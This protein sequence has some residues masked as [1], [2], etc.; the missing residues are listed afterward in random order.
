MLCK[1]VVC[2][3]D[4]RPQRAR[5]TT[6]TQTSN[7]DA[8]F[9]SLGS[10]SKFGA[11]YMED[12]GKVDTLFGGSGNDNIWLDT[13]TTKVAKPEDGT[14]L[15]DDDIM[16]GRDIAINMIATYDYFTRAN[17]RS[18]ESTL[19]TPREGLRVL[20]RGMRKTS[21]KNIEQRSIGPTET[22]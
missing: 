10:L 1:R 4:A 7:D 12:G 14:L 13:T 18:F 11:D 17:G 5:H 19:K 6:S 9:K 22:C 16:I 3:L 15:S 20:V 2:Y 8:L 21:N